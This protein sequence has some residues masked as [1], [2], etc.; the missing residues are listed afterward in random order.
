MTQVSSICWRGLV[1][2][3]WSDWDPWGWYV[4]R[5][6]HVVPSPAYC[7]HPMPDTAPGAASTQPVEILALCAI[8]TMLV[9]GIILAISSLITSQLPC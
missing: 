5:C 2:G 1:T 8:W 9:S 7:I 3:H 6:F 4:S